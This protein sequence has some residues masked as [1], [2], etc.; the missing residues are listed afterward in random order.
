MSEGNTR[1]QEPVTTSSKN[2]AFNGRISY[3]EEVASIRNR[4]AV[5]WYVL[6]LPS[7]H[8]G[9]ATGLQ[10]EA[11]RRMRTG[12]AAFEFFAPTYVEVK[13]C[14]GHLI[15][16]KRPLLFNYVFIRQSEN[17]I[18]RIKQNLPQYNFLPRIRNGAYSHYPY[19]SD[20]AMSD[21]KWISRSYS[22][23][24]PIYMP[25]TGE[26]TKGD[27]I[28]ITEGQFKGLEAS[29]AI[30]PGSGRKEVVVC[31]DNCMWVP[32]L[33]VQP[34]QYEIIELNNDNKHIYTRMGSDRLPSGLHDAMRRYIGAESVGPT[35]GDRA[36]AEEALRQYASLRMDS[37][38]MRSKLYSILLMAYTILGDQ[39]KRNETIGLIRGLLPLIK[40][41][42]SRALLLVTLYGCTDNCIYH[43]QAHAIVDRW[44]AEENPK[45]S[46]QQLIR[47]LGDYDK[48]LRH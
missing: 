20:E 43:D 47:R 7:C 48:W 45:K 10:R 2:D 19:L 5:R 23:E 3:P 12:E 9:T 13:D 46:K 37:D 24:L 6:T 35:D 14:A 40:A 32:L 17:E 33:S 11:E 15:N 42:Q 30:R 29:V 38:V 31:I 44:L 26:L 8:N 41:E 1:L 16:T 34:G 28:R 18:Y 25:E 4:N 36:L 21:L 22:D 27:R 39:A